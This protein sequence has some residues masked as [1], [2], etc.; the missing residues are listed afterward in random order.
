LGVHRVASE[1]AR[2]RGL[3]LGYGDNG[4]CGGYTD[5]V[6]GF[7]RAIAGGAL[8]SSYFE[9]CLAWIVSRGDI[10]GAGA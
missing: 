8:I 2:N 4:G 3:D 6:D 9:R 7:V 10:I 5:R 1:F